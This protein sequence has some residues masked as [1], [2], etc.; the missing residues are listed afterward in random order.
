MISYNDNNKR[1]I[2]KVLHYVLKKENSIPDNLKNRIINEMLWSATA[3]LEKKDDYKYKI[4]IWS[5]K[6]LV[7]YKTEG[8][9]GLRHEHLYPKRLLREDLCLLSKN[10]CKKKNIYKL[11]RNYS[12][13]AI[14]TENEDKILRENNLCTTIPDDYRNEEPIKKLFSRYIVCKIDLVFVTWR[15]NQP[16]SNNKYY[17]RGGNIKIDFINSIQF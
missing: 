7:H 8:K 17:L 1:N 14:I 12:H 11:L 4:P 6:A 5:T 13:A 15:N 3:D 16:V 9:K 10:N 2:A